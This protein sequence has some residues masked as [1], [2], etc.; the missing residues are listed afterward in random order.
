MQVRLDKY[1]AQL[2]LISRRALPKVIS[3]WIIAVDWEIVY[4]CDAKISYGQTI[5]YMGEDIVVL[6]NIYIAIN[7]PAG[8]ICSDI[9]EHWHA[10]YRDLLEDCPYK[11]MVHVAGR[12]DQDTEW[13]VLCSSD[14]K[15]IHQIIS[16]KKHLE[17]EYHVELENDIS[18]A[19]L[20][21]LE[22][23]VGLDDGYQTLPAKVTRIDAKTIT[24][25]ITEWKYHQVKRMLEAVWNKV[26]YLRRDRIGNWTTEGLEKRKWKQLEM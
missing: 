2:W 23:G 18:D 9:E 5:T 24:L 13:L 16:P 3:E 26:V 6:E 20:R 11:E 12:L 17:K 22:K 19:D 1:I 15:R 4:K 14:G 25:I 10:S 8:Y 7:K 21:V